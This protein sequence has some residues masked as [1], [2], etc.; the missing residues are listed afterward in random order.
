VVSVDASSAAAAG[1]A[2]C[3]CGSG[4]AS[5]GRRGSGAGGTPP[6]PTRTR[7]PMQ[8]PPFLFPIP[9]QNLQVGN[10]GAVHQLQMARGYLTPYYLAQ[11]Y[12]GNDSLTRQA[13]H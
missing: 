10:N 7:L 11:H 3:G 8:L 2:S 5:C 1:T 12:Y 4:R 13:L 9:D 6:T